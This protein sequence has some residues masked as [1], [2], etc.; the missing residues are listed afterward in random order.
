LE[1]APFKLIIGFET[2]DCEGNRGR[3]T[4]IETPGIGE[5]NLAFRR[6]NRE[7]IHGPGLD[8]PFGGIAPIAGETGENTE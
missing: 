3:P 8:R 5:A 2:F 1:L 7:E 6:Q 4:I